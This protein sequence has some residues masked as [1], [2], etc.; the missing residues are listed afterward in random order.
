MATANQPLPRPD[1]P[2]G[3]P[4][5]PPSTGAGGQQ[6]CTDVGRRSVAEIDSDRASTA[7]RRPSPV[8][9]A[10]LARP[11]QPT[12]PLAEPFSEPETARCVGTPAGFDAF[13]Y[14]LVGAGHCKPGT[15]ITRVPQGDRDWQWAD[16][17]GNA[18]VDHAPAWLREDPAGYLRALFAHD[19]GLYSV[20]TAAS[21]LG[22]L[23]WW[24]W[25]TPAKGSSSHAGRYC[26]LPVCCSRPMQLVPVGWRCRASGQLFAYR[27]TGQGAP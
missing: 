27:T 17:H 22:H 26:E 10:T 19:P 5:V 20:L 25:H 8:V 3:Q 23:N 12:G 16:D 7:R 11:C 6:T 9:A 18:L 24:H 15:P 2:T 13:G 1:E 21:T 4:S 14:H